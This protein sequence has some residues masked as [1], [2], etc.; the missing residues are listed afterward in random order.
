MKQPVLPPWTRSAETVRDWLWWQSAS[1][2]V[3]LYI[4]GKIG[5]RLVLGRHW[6]AFGTLDLA[7]LVALALAVGT[8]TWYVRWRVRREREALAQRQRQ[9]ELLL[10]ENAAVIQA[11]GAAVRELAQPLSGVLSYSE[12][13]LSTEQNNADAQREVEGLREGALHLEQL[14][15]TLR[16][17]VDTSATCDAEYHLR[18]ADAVEQSVAVSRPRITIRRDQPYRAES[19]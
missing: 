7:E 12:L 2:L 5:E 9:V 6:H 14:I 16:Q 8:A 11:I 10:A 1:L 4:A 13:L 3:A 17:T 19:G 15:Q 18:L